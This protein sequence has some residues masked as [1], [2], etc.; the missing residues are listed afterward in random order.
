MTRKEGVKQSEK[1][2]FGRSGEEPNASEVRILNDKAQHVC[3]Y[4]QWG[5]GL[6]H[7]GPFLS[8]LSTHVERFPRESLFESCSREDNG[9]RGRSAWSLI[10]ALFDCCYYSHL[11]TVCS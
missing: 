6:V 1:T 9:V 3:K 5:E 11:P 8:I 4:Q 2:T 10:S 7:T